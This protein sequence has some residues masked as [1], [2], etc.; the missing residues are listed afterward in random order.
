MPKLGTGKQEYTGSD[1]T[2]IQLDPVVL[3][4]IVGQG[5]SIGIY[6]EPLQYYLEYFKYNYD[7]LLPVE[8]PAVT[9]DTDIEI[10]ITEIHLGI[11]YHLERE[12]AG[13]YSGI[14]ISSLKE[15]L[16][17]NDGTWTFETYTPYIRLGLDM[18]FGNIRIRGEQLHFSF[19]NHYSKTS[20]LGIIIVF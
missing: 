18:I 16:T 11:N 8:N 9:A 12:L 4:T 17:Q 7:S 15:E 14:G 10:K 13:I 1:D 5:V 3:N 6:D 19:G 20:I 2:K